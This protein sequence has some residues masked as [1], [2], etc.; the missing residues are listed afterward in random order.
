MSLFSRLTGTSA[1]PNASESGQLKKIR[2]ESERRRAS[3]SGLIPK[4][5]GAS[6]EGAI[7][8]LSSRIRKGK[9]EEKS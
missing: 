3:K 8:A 5:E 1:E 9:A 4:V 7:C 2:V 6:I